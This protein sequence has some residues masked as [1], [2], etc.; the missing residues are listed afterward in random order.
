ML[1]QRALAA[2]GIGPWPGRLLDWSPNTT[3]PFGNF[4]I[5]KRTI[6]G[7]RALELSGIGAANRSLSLNDILA[8]PTFD[9]FGLD[10][11]RSYIEPARSLTLA[12]TLHLGLRHSAALRAGRITR[13]GHNNPLKNAVAIERAFKPGCVITS[14]RR[15]ARET[16]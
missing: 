13:M 1:S 9:R 12:T 14:F 4:H 6:A 5:F 11:R 7:D 10:F 3:A 15:L 16:L 8:I 2:L